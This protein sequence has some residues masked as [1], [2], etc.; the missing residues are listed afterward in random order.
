MFRSLEDS[1]YAGNRWSSQRFSRDDQ[2][3]RAETAAVGGRVV[4]ER[5]AQHGGQGTGIGCPDVTDRMHG[6]E[7]F[8]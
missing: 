5:A 2:R 1:R 8:V 3:C 7:F 4:G 6:V